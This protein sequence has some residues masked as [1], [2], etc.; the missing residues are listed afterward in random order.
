M[1]Q[2]VAWDGRQL[3]NNMHYSVG[4]VETCLVMNTVFK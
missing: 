1:E 4:E 2:K 3:Q